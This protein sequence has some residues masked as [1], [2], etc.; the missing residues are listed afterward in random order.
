MKTLF[1]VLFPFLFIGCDYSNP[2]PVDTGL[3]SKQE[4]NLYFNLYME[5]YTLYLSQRKYYDDAF[6]KDDDVTTKY[7]SAKMNGTSDA[8]KIIYNHLH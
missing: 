8:M 1:L 7:W 2:C 5:E 6:K 3:S 4:Y